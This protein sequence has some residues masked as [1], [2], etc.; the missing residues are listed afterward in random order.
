MATDPY[1]TAKASLRENVKT[2]VAVFGGIAGVLLA[3]T[4]FSGYGAL[5]LLSPRWWTASLA[6]L[7]ALLLLGLCVWRLLFILRPDLTYTRLLVEPT[8]DREIQALQAE[9]AKYKDELLPRVKPPR[10]AMATVQDL[11]DAKT[12]AWDAFQRDKTSEPKRLAHERLADALAL[13]N[14]WSGFTRLHIRVSRG[15]RDVLSVGVLIILCIA[16][17][18]LAASSQKDKPEAAPT[19]S[20]IAAPEPAPRDLPLPRLA[21]VE[22]DSGRSELTAQALQRLEE[23]RNQLRAHPQ[24]GLLI[25]ANTDTV[26]SDAFN[27]GLAAARA[28]RVLQALRAQGGISA[29][30]LFVARLGEQDLPALTAQQTASQAN[31]AVEMLLVPLPVRAAASGAR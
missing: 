7:A 26:G 11:L 6:L 29:S 18:V 31:R 8:Q 2:L 23:A 14:H 30:R 5:E 3:G 24:A 25:L 17:F 28:A 19:I 9:F 16:V 1:S 4:P 27:Q 10:P 15:V 13:V 21:P 20:V 12:A 22:F